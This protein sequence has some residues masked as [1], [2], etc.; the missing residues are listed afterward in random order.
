MGRLTDGLQ[1]MGTI[2]L[3]AYGVIAIHTASAQA[4]SVD[5]VVLT[6]VL[7]QASKDM[8]MPGV[9]AALIF[10][11]G[12]IVRAAIGFADVEAK[13]KLD[14][15]VGMPGGSTGKTF[16]AAL[17]LLLVE[18][19]V[20][21]LDDL[22]SLWLGEREWFYRLPNAKDIRVW[23][24]L[25]HTSGI[26]DYPGTSGY[27]LASI[28]R[29]IRHG[30]IK[31]SPE[32]LIQFAISKKALFPPGEGYYY[33]DAGYL[34]LGRLLEAAT[35]E[36]YYD[37]LD[38]Y[39][40]TPHQLNEIQPAKHAILTN[41]TPGYT[42]GARNLRKDGSMKIDPT[43]E[44]TGGGLVTNP[45]M[46]VKFYSAMIRG[47]IV[48][49]G[50]F[51]QML[52][53]GWRD[54]DN[55]YAYYGLGLFI[56]DKDTFSHAGLWPG[57]RTQV[58]HFKSKNITIAVQTNRDGLVDLNAIVSRIA[59]LLPDQDTFQDS[60]IVIDTNSNSCSANNNHIAKA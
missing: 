50:S 22:A 38:K 33:S 12:Q 23:H 21:S 15:T 17:T 18:D 58:T 10:G 35:G 2:I 51:K 52:N 47:E 44:W 13:I 37:L 59:L 45:T 11:D 8:S 28:W 43:S 3:F 27:L 19:G 7:E 49:P 57:Y 29:G 26:K 34:V 46:L 40:L 1:R 41:I 32:E 6:K 14:N 39:I 36:T 53:C 20:L 5:P 55:P 48:K 25:S 60:N 24:L 42:L 56:Y 30:T 54:L 31:F 16:V 9:R 4:K